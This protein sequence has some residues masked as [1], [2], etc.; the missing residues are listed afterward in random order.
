MYKSTIHNNKAI[1]EY[2]VYVMVDETPIE[3]YT[4]LG[5]DAVI[6]RVFKLKEIKGIETA[7]FETK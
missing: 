5:V 7:L 1:T 3:A 4:E 2:I 6:D